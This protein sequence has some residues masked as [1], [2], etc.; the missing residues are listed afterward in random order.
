MLIGLSIILL[1]VLFLPFT[2]FVE[3]NLEVFLF[4][5]G[6]AAVIVSSVFSWHLVEE[7]L[8]H[9]ISITIAVLVAGLIFKWFQGPIEKGILWISNVM[10]FRLFIAL[11]VI[12]LSLLS[13]VITAIVAAVILAAVISVLRLDR[14]SEIRLAVLA[15][16][17]IGLGAVLTP[18]G[19]PLSTIVVNKLNEDFFYLLNLVGTS[20]IPFVV[21]FGIFAAFAVKKKSDAK[22][23]IASGKETSLVQAL[24]EENGDSNKEQKTEAESY[25]EIIIRSLKIYLFVMALTFLGAGFEPFITAYLLDM[26]PLVMYWINIVSAVL[27]NATLAAAEISPAMDT[28]TIS[29]ILMGLLIS[30]GMLIPGN[31][32]NIITAGKLKIT[33]MEYARFAFPIGLAAMVVYFIII[34]VV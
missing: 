14:Q 9:P 8:L 5:M 19:E 18:I 11:F 16:F 30:G 4:I 6:I 31:I 10:P 28:T 20:V 1:L 22:S 2:H 24:E 21:I 26:S 13:S 17:A 12:I 29:N 15:C 3:K 23:E 7:A 25:G 34:L 33:S 27:D 32:P